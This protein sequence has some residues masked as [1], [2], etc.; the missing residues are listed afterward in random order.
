MFQD[1]L[2]REARKAKRRQAR[3]AVA[4]AGVAILVAVFVVGVV[5]TNL[6]LAGLFEGGDEAPVATTSRITAPAGTTRRPLTPGERIGRP[7][8]LAPT[9]DV[10]APPSPPQPAPS[11]EPPRPDPADELARERFKDALAIFREEI[12]P[13]VADPSFAAWNAAAQA[14]ILTGKEAAVT[15]FG[16]ARYADALAALEAADATA[17]REIAA[18]DAAFDEA[19]LGA[20]LAYEGDDPDRANARIAEALRLRPES[21]EAQALAARIARL[22][23]LLAETNAAAIARV[24]G[25]LEAEAAH[26]AAA[27]AIDPTRQELVDRLAAVRAEILERRFTGHIA[28]GLDAVAAR[29]LGGARRNLEGARAVFPERDEV[30]VLAARIAELARAL[31][32]ERNVAAAEDAARNDDW[33]RAEER[34]AD[35]YRL[36]PDNAALGDALARAKAINALARTIESFLAAPD[37]FSSEGVTVRA[38]DAVAQVASLGEA[39]PSLAARADELSAL[40]AAYARK[41]PVRVVSDGLTTITVRGVGHVGETTGRTIELR[42]GRYTFEGTRAGFRSKLVN[43]DIPPGAENVVLEIVTDER[44]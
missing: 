25:N 39:S 14:G 20:R 11:T 40:L 42:P 27:L 6:D 19:L 7:A 16:E 43:I 29:D 26:L 28:A 34:Y 21:T 38:K 13:L 18:R 5:S 17:R 10:S 15:A 23:E 37:R 12:E 30:A 24:E 8:E 1:R 31:D 3:F 36:A 33:P 22:P 4:L 9:S 44:I 2:E 32:I 35:A 41:V